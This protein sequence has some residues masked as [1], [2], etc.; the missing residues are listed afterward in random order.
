MIKPKYFYRPNDY[1]IFHKLENGKYTHEMNLK[2]SWIG[3]EYEYDI[4]IKC[5]FVPCTEA[6]L[7]ALK[8]KHDLY[9]EWVTWSGRSDGHGGCKGGTMEEY[10]K[11]L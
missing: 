8:E 3:H 9:Y 10:L 6:E 2:H 1:S 11:T 7:P 5:G 4:L